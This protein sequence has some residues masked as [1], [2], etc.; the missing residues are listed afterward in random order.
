M[1]IN[2]KIVHLKVASGQKSHSNKNGGAQDCLS[3]DLITKSSF[4]KTLNFH[5]S[6]VFFSINSAAE[7]ALH[8]LYFELATSNCTN[9]QSQPTE[10]VL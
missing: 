3:I 5:Q 4:H 8:G 10:T 1:K 7:I 2:L 9:Q 6:Q